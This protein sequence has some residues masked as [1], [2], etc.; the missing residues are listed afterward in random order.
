MYNFLNEDQ[1]DTLKELINIGLGAATSNIAELLDAFATIHVPTIVICNSNQLMHLIAEN[2]DIE[3]KCYVV[4]QLFAGRFSGESMFVMQDTS[5]NELGNHLYDIKTPS[6][7]DINDAVMELTN[8]L[9]ST[10]ISRVTNELGTSVQ[11]FVPSSQYVDS[12]KILD[13]DD[14]KHYTSIIAI[15][16]ILDFQDQQINGNIYILTRDESIDDLKSLIDEKLK[17]LYS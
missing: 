13:Y 9:T 14:I 5:A 6:H 7:D 11:F 4:K 15:S 17:E 1:E 16:T 8:I 3:S 10:I 2:M 12:E